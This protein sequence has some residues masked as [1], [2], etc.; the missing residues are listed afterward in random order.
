MC[1]SSPKGMRFFLDVSSVVPGMATATLKA[2]DFIRAPSLADFVLLLLLHFSGVDLALH[3]RGM[4][5]LCRSITWYRAS[6]IHHITNSLSVRRC[7]RFCTVTTLMHL[8]TTK[9]R[10]VSH[11]YETGKAALSWQYYGWH[12]SVRYMHVECQFIFTLSSDLIQA[13]FVVVSLIHFHWFLFSILWKRALVRRSHYQNSKFST[14]V[15]IFTAL[16]LSS[17][18]TFDL[19]VL[20]LNHVNLWKYMFLPRFV[21]HTP[22][23]LPTAFSN[24]EL[25]GSK[26]E[27]YWFKSFRAKLFTFPMVCNIQTAII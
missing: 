23:V 12:S 5:I 14:H 1:Q 17:I 11:N 6:C 16:H 26:R 4:T 8:G 15:R 27:R 21:Q 3:P 22:L 13:L 20:L 24:F 7:S 10:P 19:P 25:V 18:L 2:Q 9:V